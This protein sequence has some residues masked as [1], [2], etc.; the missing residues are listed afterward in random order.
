MSIERP[1]TDAADELADLWV[2][3][4]RG[5]RAHGSHLLSAENRARIR[6]AIGRHIVT[7]GLLVA[8]DGD[9][10]VGFVMFSPETNEYEQDVTRG[11]IHNIYVRETHRGAGVG[12]DLLAAA[13]DALRERGTDAVTLEVMADN[14]DARRFYRSRGYTPHRVEMEK[15]LDGTESDTP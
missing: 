4:A 3:L 13:E 8:R 2:A 12:A 11:V 9:D 7:G 5:Q 1:D 14:E 10:I 6:E 15:P